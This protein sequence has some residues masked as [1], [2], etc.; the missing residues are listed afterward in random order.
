MAYWKHHLND[1]GLLGTDTICGKPW[2]Y[3]HLVQYTNEDIEA[4]SF[5]LSAG[6]RTLP[7]LHADI[8]RGNIKHLMEVL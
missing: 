4:L 3:Q 7:E 5:T 6:D 1:F 2:Y 8:K